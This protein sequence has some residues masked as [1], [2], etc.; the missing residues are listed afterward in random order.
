MIKLVPISITRP[1]PYLITCEWSDGF[2]STITAEKLRKGCPCADCNKDEKKTTGFQMISLNTIKPGTNDLKSLKK[3]GNYAVSAVW[4][5]GHDT[6]IYSWDVL[7]DI[8][9]RNSLTKDQVADLEK[10]FG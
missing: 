10:K 3:V 5:D 9:E 4:G 2:V 6:G 1:K 8:F 7:R